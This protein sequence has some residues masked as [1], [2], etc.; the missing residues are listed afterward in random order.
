MP[1][2]PAST[3]TRLLIVAC[4]WAAPAI[5]SAGVLGDLTQMFMSNASGPRATSSQDRAGVFGGSVQLR[6]PILAINLVA[7]DPP[8]FDAGCGGIDQIGRAHV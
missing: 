6:A 2:K 7:F 5:A 1:A 8:R 3:A 4:L